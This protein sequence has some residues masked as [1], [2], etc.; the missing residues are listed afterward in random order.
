MY[1][2]RKVYDEFYLLET[3]RSLVLTRVAAGWRRSFFARC[4]LGIARPEI[5]NRSSSSRSYFLPLVVTY[6]RARPPTYTARRL[7][8]AIACRLVAGSPPRQSR[9]VARQVLC[10][11]NSCN[12]CAA[13]MFRAAAVCLLLRFVRFARSLAL[14]A[15]GPAKCQY[16]CS[17]VN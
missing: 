9:P 6:C 5:P 10:F 16:G 2:F 7:S 4:C 15:F 1:R 17:C 12:S 3:W 11:S 13:A 8:R 14:A